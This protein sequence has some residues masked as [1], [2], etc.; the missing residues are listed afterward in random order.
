MISSKELSRRETMRAIGTL[1]RVQESVDS[2]LKRKKEI[3][4]CN[5]S[6]RGHWYKMRY[7]MQFREG[8]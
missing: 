7:G 8:R 4:Q 1:D 3:T 2:F 6:R 5:P